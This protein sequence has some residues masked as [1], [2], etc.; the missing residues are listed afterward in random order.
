[1]GA[2]VGERLLAAGTPLVVHNRTPEKTEQLAGAGAHVAR[3]IE[4]LAERVD[5]V[6]T[7]LSDDD[8]LAAVAAAIAR[9]ARPGT[10]LVDLSTV[11][12]GRSAEVAALLAA[13]RVSYLRA[14][15]SGNP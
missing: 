3:S 1:M 11:S 9:S 4:A 15:V 5:V 8:A 10:V 2:A 14:P 12:P 7:S 13:A 6:L